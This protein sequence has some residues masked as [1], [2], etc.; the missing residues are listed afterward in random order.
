[1]RLV[2]TEVASLPLILVCYSLDV[3]QRT[4]F[5]FVCPEVVSQLDY[6]IILCP[7]QQKI[8]LSSILDFV[9]T[10]PH[11]VS[12]PCAQW[13]PLHIYTAAAG[14]VMPLVV[15]CRVWMWTNVCI[16]ALRWPCCPWLQCLCSG[17][18]AEAGAMDHSTCS[19]WAC[20]TE[21]SRKGIFHGASQR[22]AES[23]HWVFT[24]ACVSWMGMD[25]KIKT[26]AGLFLAY[27][28]LLSQSTKKWKR[29]SAVKICYFLGKNKL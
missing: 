15:F 18:V 7:F 28:K 19:F 9:R 17:R 10:Q 23:L 14:S 16:S 26:S 24:A 29:G 11:S 1:M 25:I 5:N 6:M 22:K 20:V 4:C 3:T 27:E 8:L 13:R 2:T 12:K 21:Q